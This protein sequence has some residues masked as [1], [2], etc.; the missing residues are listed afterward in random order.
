[1]PR[2][3]ARRHVGR[4]AL[5]KETSDHTKYEKVVWSTTEAD[6]RAKMII[7]IPEHHLIEIDDINRDR[8]S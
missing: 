5:L 7:F 8:A 6:A 1:L 2:S 3:P 4:Q